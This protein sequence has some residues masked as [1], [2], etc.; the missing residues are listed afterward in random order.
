MAFIG[1]REDCHKLLYV[2]KH[3]TQALGITVICDT[4][5]HEHIH[6]IGTL[7]MTREIELYMSVTKTGEKGA[8]KGKNVITTCVMNC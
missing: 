3:T 7:Y 5:L 4:Y 2:Q 8:K 1:K 6:N